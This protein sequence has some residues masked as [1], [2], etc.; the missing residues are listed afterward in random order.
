MYVSLGA[1][2]RDAACSRGSTLE[3]FSEW[4]IWIAIVLLVLT[5]G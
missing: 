4:W 3:S 2:R 1:D 5:V